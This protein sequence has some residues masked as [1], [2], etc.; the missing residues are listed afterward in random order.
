MKGGRSAQQV[1]PLFRYRLLLKPLYFAALTSKSSDL[2]GEILI[3]DYINFYRTQN[4][5]QQMLRC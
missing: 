3:P 5:R 4:G 1:G 2:S